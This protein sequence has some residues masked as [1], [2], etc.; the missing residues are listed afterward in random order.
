MTATA[1]GWRLGSTAQ[2]TNTKETRFRPLPIE[3]RMLSAMANQSQSEIIKQNPI[4][5]GLEGFRASYRSV[6]NSKSIPYAPDT[7]DQ[8]D[9]KGKISTASTPLAPLTDTQ[10]SR[11]S[12]LIFS[13]HCRPF[14]LRVHS[15]L[16][17]AGKIS[18]ATC[19]GS[20]PPSTPTTP[21]ST[22][23]DPS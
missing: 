1:Y 14:E 9:H 23:S 13:R 17:A 4:G 11:I 3:K 2:Q 22:A 6:C 19:C 12:L 20:P 18:S 16:V 10:M 21:T 5:N 8:L 7:L 15:A